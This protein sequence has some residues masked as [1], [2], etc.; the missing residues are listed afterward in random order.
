MVAQAASAAGAPPDRAGAPPPPS[1]HPGS[2]CTPAASHG[3]YGGVPGPGRAAHAARPTGH[4]PP[5]CGPRVDE[6]GRHRV[7]S[8]SVLGRPHSPYF[9]RLREVTHSPADF[10]ISD[11]ETDQRALCAHVCS[12]VP[13]SLVQRCWKLMPCPIP[14]WP[15][16]QPI[17]RRT[18]LGSSVLVHPISSTRLDVNLFASGLHTARL[19]GS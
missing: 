2:P 11:C 16:W 19:L 3:G 18:V 15:L 1:G 9:G 13:T 17:A 4:R 8:L 10:W 7:V 12:T 6:E 5:E 14:V